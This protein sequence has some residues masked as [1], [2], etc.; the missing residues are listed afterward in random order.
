MP[1]FDDNK[2]VSLVLINSDKG[3]LFFEKIKQNLF[4]KETRIEDAMQPVF[5]RPSVK[6]KSRERF[7]RD[8]EARG[9]DYI[10]KKYVGPV[11]RWRRLVQ[12]VKRT[13]N[14]V[15]PFDRSDSS[16]GQAVARKQTPVVF[17]GKEA[18]CGCTACYASCPKS[19]I[20]MRPDEEGFDYPAIDEAMCIKCGICQNVCPITGTGHRASASDNIF[21][22]DAGK[23]P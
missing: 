6:P 10:V 11:P 8:Y 13:I 4:W 1:E 23:H 12:K 3:A 17:T 18:C 9:F 22:T 16:K 7:W 14:K 15:W 20:S 5:I 19:A 2:G 21:V